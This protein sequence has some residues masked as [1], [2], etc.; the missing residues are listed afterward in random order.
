MGNTRK[1]AAV[2]CFFLPILFLCFA[3]AQEPPSISAASAVLMDADSGRILYANNE[4]EE[5]PIA[6]ITKLMTALVVAESVEDL[7][8][9]VVIRPEWTGIEGT[10]LYLRPGETLSV[11]CLLYGLLLQ[12]GNDAAVALAGYSAGDVE[13]FVAWMN[14]RAADLGMSH[15]HFYDP[16]G[17]SS[18]AH[19]SSAWDMAKLAAACLKH[20][21]IAEIVSTRSIHLEGRTLTN[22]NKLLWRYPA[23]T[24]MKTGFTRQAGRTLVSSAEKDG[25]TLIC[26][27]LN[28]PEDWRDHEALLEYGFSTYPRQ[29]LLEKGKVLGKLPVSGSLL[30]QVSISPRDDF[31]YPIGQSDAVEITTVEP[32]D[33]V[34]APLHQD[35][36]AGSVSVLVN[37]RTVGKVYLIWKYS[38]PRDVLEMH[39]EISPFRKVR[40]WSGS[41]FRERNAP[42]VKNGKTL[43]LSASFP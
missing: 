26:V 4:S 11:K 12:S 42:F 18:D 34:A 30:H 29:K 27:T 36:I 7:E 14:Q 43:N 2:F 3:H 32:S 35:G 22:H 16:N 40:Q 13:A 24:G 19:Y 21:V 28:D 37:G 33:P 10:S 39:D 41:L 25:Q 6:S 31:Y 9:K 15:T 20:P 8:K 38:V 17:L 5:R 23:C 1:V